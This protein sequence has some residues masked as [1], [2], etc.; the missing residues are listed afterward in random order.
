MF[1]VK[2]IQSI[3]NFFGIRLSRYQPKPNLV[4]TNLHLKKIRKKSIIFDIGANIGT[5]TN[6]YLTELSPQSIHTFEPN[7]EAFK[8]LKTKY[9]NNKKVILNNCAVGKKKGTKKLN[10]TLKSG[11]SSFYNLNPK[12][13]WINE[14]ANIYKIKP[15]HYTF[16][17]KNS[18]IITIDDYVK[19][20]KIKTIDLMK[21]DTQ[22]FEKNILEGSRNSLKKIIKNIELEIMLDDCYEVKMS[23]YEIEKILD[24][25]NFKL[26][27]LYSNKRDIFEKSNFGAF[28]FYSKEN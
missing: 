18:T 24:P 2:Y 14:K 7:D 15:E 22:G 17:K 12:S 13:E 20:N 26:I 11:N 21:I 1:L 10:Y 8:I 9:F 5:V 3:F 16:K 19:K 23:F 27:G 28:V 4:F 25:F 6:K